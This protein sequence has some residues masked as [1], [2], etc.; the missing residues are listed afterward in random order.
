MG[1]RDKSLRFLAPLRIA[2]KGHMFSLGDIEKRT[3]NFAIQAFST[4]FYLSKSELLK[5]LDQVEQAKR[6]FEKTF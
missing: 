5:I 6:I 1:F 3:L 2:I 4:S